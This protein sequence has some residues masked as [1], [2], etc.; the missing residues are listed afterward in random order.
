MNLQSGWTS[1]F[2]G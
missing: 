1:A 2:T